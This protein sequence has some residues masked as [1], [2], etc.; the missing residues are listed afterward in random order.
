LVERAKRH[1]TAEVHQ[2]LFSDAAPG[3]KLAKP[4]KPVKSLAAP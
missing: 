4:A 2:A 3:A 1:T